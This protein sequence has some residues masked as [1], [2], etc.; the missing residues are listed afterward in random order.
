MLDTILSCLSLTE[1]DTDLYADKLPVFFLLVVNTFFSGVDNAGEDLQGVGLKLV[2]KCPD[3]CLV[4]SK[5]R[6]QTVIDLVIIVPVLGLTYMLTLHTQSV[7]LLGQP[8]CL[9]K[10]AVITLP[11][12][13]LILINY[14]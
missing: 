10:G 2:Y 9:H 14:H 1:R 5:L 8:N 6:S 13:Y 12:C 3:K 11:Y 4:V 7:K